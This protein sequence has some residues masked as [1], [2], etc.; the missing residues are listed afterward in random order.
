MYE[1]IINSNTTI[2][3][4]LGMMTKGVHAPKTLKKRG[5]LLFV[6]REVLDV[7]VVDCINSTVQQDV[8]ASTVHYPSYIHYYCIRTAKRPTACGTLSSPKSQT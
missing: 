2:T 5:T 7:H 3:F 4:I 8:C 6:D 1:Y